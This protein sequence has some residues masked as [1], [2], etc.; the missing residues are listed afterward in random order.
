M[1]VAHLRPAPYNARR[2]DSVALAG[3][4][5]SIER[6]GNVQPVVWNQRSGFVVGGHQR[7]KVLRANKVKTTEV[8]VVDLDEKEERALNVALNNPHIAGEFTADLQRLLEEIKADD[9]AFFA[10]LRLDELLVDTE[11]EGQTVD[12]DAIPLPPKVPKTRP[13]DVYLLGDHR[14]IC[15]DCR[16]E[17]V[18]AKLFAG[19]TINMAM[20]SP[21]YQRNATTT[22]LRVSSRYRR[23]STPSGSAALPTPCAYTSPQTARSASTSK[24]TPSQASDHSMS[25]TSLS[26][27]C[28]SGTGAWWKSSAGRMEAR[29]KRH[30]DD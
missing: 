4:T 19:K 18:L 24:S 26:H 9:G 17:A 11:P 5:K 3:L 14:L 16:D 1:T 29:P 13:G 27:S 10:D 28:A 22:T 30:G 8:V 12:P 23:L 2:I 7:L 6:F 21:P 20:T 25:K 15:G